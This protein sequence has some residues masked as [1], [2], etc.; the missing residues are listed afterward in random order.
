MSREKAKAVLLEQLTRLKAGGHTRVQLRK[1]EAALLS[2][3]TTTHSGKLWFDT[4][5]IVI[6]DG[7]PEPTTVP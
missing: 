5:E 4:V 1:A 7:P 3:L 2:S 6:L